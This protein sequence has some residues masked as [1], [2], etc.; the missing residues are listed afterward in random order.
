MSKINEK[1]EALKKM[2]KELGEVELSVIG[3]FTLADAMREGSK[4]SKHN[5]NGWGDGDTACALLS[6]IISARSR[7]YV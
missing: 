5:Q 7:D 1:A 4:V 6:V 3:N 2:R